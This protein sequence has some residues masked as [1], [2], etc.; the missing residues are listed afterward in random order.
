[1]RR[2]IVA[3]CTFAAISAL[4]GF[5]EAQERSWYYCSTTHS[6]YPYTQRCAIPW[7]TVRPYQPQPLV[8]APR[9][10]QQ[11]QPP[12][13]VSPPQLVPNGAQQA[14]QD[15]QA[16]RQKEQADAAVLAQVLAKREA[17]QHERAIEKAKS[18]GYELIPNVKDLILD[19]KELAFEGG[20]IQISGIFKK[21]AENNGMLY[22]SPLDVYSDDDN[23]VPVLTDD[24]QRDLREY[25]MDYACEA[26]SGCAVEVGGHM[27]KCK[28]INALLADASP[29]PCS[30]MEVQIIY[31]PGD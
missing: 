24:A 30:H 29:V 27:T 26:E 13:T 11:P 3:V 12:E 28:H 2:S 25:L 8:G 5:C 4:T 7:R 9:Q 15:Q 18:H 10:L 16:A 22:G 14:Q 19:S 20:K 21:A 17:Y 1:M 31:R 6:F 23:Y